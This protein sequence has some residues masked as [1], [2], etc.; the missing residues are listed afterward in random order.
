MPKALT[1][2]YSERIAL[3]VAR[4]IHWLP[5]WGRGAAEGEDADWGGF[6]LTCVKVR[7]TAIRRVRID[8]RGD[9]GA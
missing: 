1:L 9:D 5:R 8:L 7:G 2:E 3:V 6:R 4:P